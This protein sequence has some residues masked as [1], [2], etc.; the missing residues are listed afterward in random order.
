MTGKLYR[1]TQATI[2]GIVYCVLQVQQ[3]YSAMTIFLW[4]IGTNALEI[5]L[6]VVRT[7][8]HASNVD[9]KALGEC[10]GADVALEEIYAKYPGWAKKCRRL[11]NSI[12]H[13][14][15][16]SWSE[17]GQTGSCDVRDVNVVEFWNEVRIT[18]T[19]ALQAHGDYKDV[20]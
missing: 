7:L 14:N 20:A 11:N 6:A 12:N 16:R 10:L 5:L 4:Q 15:V 17:G 1:D 13:V 8:T 9:G 19:S 3:H 2:L 18:A